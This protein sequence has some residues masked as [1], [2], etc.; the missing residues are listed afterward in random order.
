MSFNIVRSG[1]LA[2]ALA[3]STFAVG[4]SAQVGDEAQ[5]EDSDAEIVSRSAHFETFVGLDGQYYFDFV[6]GNGQN[7]LRS[8]GYQ[9]AQGAAKGIASGSISSRISSAPPG[10]RVKKVRPLPGGQCWSR[11]AGSC[12]HPSNRP[13]E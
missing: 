3:A 11:S 5:V 8:E 2:L 1:L 7:V 4:C 10:G 12:P 13:V 6:A 9:T